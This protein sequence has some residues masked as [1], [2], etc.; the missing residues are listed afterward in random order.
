MKHSKTTG[1]FSVV[2]YYLCN[3]ALTTFSTNKAC[4]RLLNHK[5][6]IVALERVNELM[7]GR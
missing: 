3:L 1:S 2:A 7:I 4:W 5:I 6:L